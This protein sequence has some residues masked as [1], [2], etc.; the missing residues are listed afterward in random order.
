MCIFCK[1]AKKEVD[2]YV[3]YEDEKTMAFLDINPVSKGHT[4]VIPKEHYENVLEMPT[5]LGRDLA[6]TVQIV[7]EKLKK[8]GA[9]GF[10][11]ITNIG[12]V[13][14]QVV[15]HAH[16]HVI[17]RYSSEES[18]PIS[19]GKPIECDLEEVYKALL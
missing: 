9:E 15:M 1:I 2:A 7:C 8:L 3:L 10:N 13:A 5:E 11:V 16:I 6:K 12:G 4:L 14:G 18:R 19:F 17:P